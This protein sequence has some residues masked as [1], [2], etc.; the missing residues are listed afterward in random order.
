MKRTTLIPTVLSAVLLAVSACSADTPDGADGPADETD[1]TDGPPGTDDSGGTPTRVDDRGRL[2][3]VAL[4]QFDECGAFLDY[5]HTEGAE[6][7]GAYGFDSQRY[8][9]G[10][11]DVMVMESDVAATDAM[12]EGAASGSDRV[13]SDGDEFG[14]DFST[15][16][17]QVEGVDEPDIVKTDGTRILAVSE[18]GVLHYVDLDDEGAAGELRG[19]VSITDAAG[20]NGYVYGQEILVSGDR[21]FVV[22]RGERGVPEPFP[23]DDV[24]FEESMPSEP[25]PGPGGNFGPTTTVVE[26]DLSNPDE[27]RI[28]GSLTLDGNYISARSIGDTARIA[29]TTPPTQ[30]GFLFPSS[31]NAEES[32]AEAN[33]EIVRNTTVDDWVPGFSLTTADGSQSEGALVDCSSIHAPA[34]FAGFDLLSVVTLPMDES[35]SAPAATTSIMATGDTVYASQDRMYISTNEWVQPTLDEQQRG[36]WEENYQT[37]I[38]R[39]ALP[40]DGAAVYEASGTVDG[41]LLNQFSMH[42]RDGTFF[43]ATTTGT[44]WSSRQS[45]SQIIAMQP[46][47]EVLEQIG[48]VG[49]L[50]KGERIFSVRYVDQTAYVVTFRQTDPFYV[51]DLSSPTEMVVRGELK[52]PGVSNYLHPIS[53][54]LVLGVGQDATED[55][56]QTGSKVSLFDVSDPSNPREVDVWTM[57]GASSD[58]EFD[59]RAFL[60][61]A[62][63]ATAVLPLVSWS[64]QFA[65]AV[66]LTVTEDGIS[67]QGRV[68]HRDEAEEPTGVTDCRVLTSDDVQLDENDGELFWILQEPGSQFQLCGAE[69]EGGATGHSCEAIP[70]SDVGNVVWTGEEDEFPVD[71]T[72]ADR[73]EWCWPDDGF[74]GYDERIQRTLVIGDQLWTMSPAGLQANDLAT[75][76][77]TTAVAF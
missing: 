12:E 5:V 50:G 8:W 15:T 54:A 69:D 62:P 23:V 28:A 61:W 4:R 53:D 77:R 14:T 71:L 31:P 63:T 56:R 46:N 34:E 26:V 32:A 19:S 18:N 27:L 76:D 43:V 6:R 57:P 73:I 51:V 70:V 64:D 10:M 9:L 7:V 36:V 17:V 13:V 65:G 49:G 11:D 35:L 74:D 58:A 60:W 22:A 25:F 67:E 2:A 66:V 39:F 29:V 24:V 52:I 38:H 37:G 41:H 1:G 68:S 48:H 47:G 55:G 20:P 44:P 72:G 40:A 45:E 3:K 59:H 21:A 42:D 75:L 33:R 16:N 30:L